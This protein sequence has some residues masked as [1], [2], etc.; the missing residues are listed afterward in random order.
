MNMSYIDKCKTLEKELLKY[1]LWGNLVPEKSLKISLRRILSKEEWDILSKAVYKKAKYTCYICGAI[2]HRLEIYEKWHY[3]YN[4]SIQQLSD[5]I[6]LCDLCFLNE[7][8][9]KKH[10]RAKLILHWS[11][12]NDEDYNNFEKYEKLVLELRDLRNNFD[13]KVV[14]HLG[15]DIS[16]GV[17]LYDLLK[18]VAK[19]YEG[20]YVP[21][22]QNNEISFTSLED[23]CDEFEKN[24]SELKRIRIYK[25]NKDCWK[26][27]KETPHVSYCLVFQ[28]LV[29]GCIGE[30]EKIDEILIKEYPFV[31]RVYSKTQGKRVIGNTCV[32]CGAYQGNFFIFDEII[33]YVDEENLDKTIPNILNDDDLPPIFSQL[34]EFEINDDINNTDLNDIEFLFDLG[35]DYKDKHNYEYALKIFNRILQLE[36]KESDALVYIGEIYAERLEYDKAIETYKAVLKI[37]PEDSMI[38]ELDILLLEMEKEFSL[39]F[40]EI[41]ES[42][43]F[44]GVL[45]LERKPIIYDIRIGEGSGYYPVREEC[46]NII[47]PKDKEF[48]EIFSNVL[49]RNNYQIDTYGTLYGEADYSINIIEEV[50]EDR[51]IVVYFEKKVRNE[52]KDFHAEINT[53]DTLE[54]PKDTKA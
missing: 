13:W 26:C 10:D 8:L 43:R 41:C 1:K 28:G 36:P 23:I 7:H 35:Q 45:V 9:E 5:M 40:Y 48:F 29:L 32:H 38:S 34:E 12:V 14:D 44:E 30:I 47:L 17:K 6:T 18:L 46:D 52:F 37:D 15:N 25:W 31:K 19:D 27:F 16:K 3:D 49:A 11:S 21:N 2:T 53:Y 20:E 50:N 39:N 54:I 33:H 22:S 42:I 4:S 51:V 24:I